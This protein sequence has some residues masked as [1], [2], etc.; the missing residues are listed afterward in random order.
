MQKHGNN[1]SLFLVRI[2][3]RAV[4]GHKEQVA[5][6]RHHRYRR[7]VGAYQSH[8]HGLILGGLLL[9]SMIRTFRQQR[10]HRLPMYTDEYSSA[11]THANQICFRICFSSGENRST[12]RYCH[13]SALRFSPR[14]CAIRKA[15]PRLR[16]LMP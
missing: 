5:K 2:Y 16:W 11:I 7:Q 9:R 1:L 15:R 8:S 10:I 4:L 6:V 13:L 14:S 3:D 12:P